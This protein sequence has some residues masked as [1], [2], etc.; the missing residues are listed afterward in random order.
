MFEKLNIWLVKYPEF[1]NENTFKN[2][3]KNCLTNLVNDIYNQTQFQFLK[4]WKQYLQVPGK[5]SV[6]TWLQKGQVE[7]SKLEEITWKYYKDQLS[8]NG[9]PAKQ[10]KV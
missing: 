4:N 2:V 1:F 7:K 6:A 8:V 10:Q 5:W 9:P 3:T